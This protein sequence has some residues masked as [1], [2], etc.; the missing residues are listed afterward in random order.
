MAGPVFLVR[1]RRAQLQQWAKDALAALAA[2]GV[3]LL[4]ATAS[5]A[6]PLAAHG[7][8]QHREQEEGVAVRHSKPAN[9]VS[10]E[11][12][13]RILSRL[14]RDRPD[15]LERVKSG[16]FKSARAAAIEAGI[17]KPVPTVR[18]VD[19]AAK[20]PRLRKRTARCTLFALSKL[21]NCIHSEVAASGGPV[22]LADVIRR[23]RQRRL[24]RQK[25]SPG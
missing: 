5:K 1:Q 20:A 23:M 4:P 16:E 3:T 13:D 11:S 14:A 17:I 18:L 7:T 6:Q 22:V 21:L 24:K 2:V 8:N 10:S 15:I 9:Q 19:D 12:W 25:Y